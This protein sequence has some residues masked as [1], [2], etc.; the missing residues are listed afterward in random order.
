MA[1]DGLSSSRVLARCSLG[2]LAAAAVTTVSFTAESG[3][4]VPQSA[5]AKVAQDLPVN[6]HPV[7]PVTPRALTWQALTYRV[8]KSALEYCAQ[9]YVD[10]PRAQADSAASKSTRM[11]ERARESLAGYW[12]EF[13]LV[14]GRHLRVSWFKGKMRGYKHCMR[15]TH[16]E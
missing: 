5:H 2:V 6:F 1:G 15:L 3:G 13:I 7:I 4:G 11:L 10:S 8:G 9:M 12:Y 14:I 16:A